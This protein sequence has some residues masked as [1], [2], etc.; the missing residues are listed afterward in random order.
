MIHER[1]PGRLRE[2][3][4]QQG[5]VRGFQSSFRPLKGTRKHAEHDC[6]L[7]KEPGTGREVIQV[8]VHD[9]TER[10]RAEDALRQ[11]EE[12]YRNMFEAVSESLVIFD[13]RRRVVAANPS[14]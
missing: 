14:T 8:V 7:V 13:L 10:K 11:S 6:Y 12:Q 1:P 9:I 3:V 2:Q 4:R 5:R